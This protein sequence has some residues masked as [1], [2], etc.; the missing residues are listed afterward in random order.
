MSDSQ[1]TLHWTNNQKE[2]LKQWVRIKVVEIN[3]L[4]Q[5]KD[6]MFV[7][8]EDMIADIGTRRISD[9]HAVGK[10]SVWINRFDWIKWGKASFPAKTIDEI[11]LNSEEIPAL[12]NEILKYRSETA[13]FLMAKS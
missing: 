8:N 2:P 4:T 10:D 12:E 6:W 11:K 13:K 1:V 9:F 5:P 3:R 7:R